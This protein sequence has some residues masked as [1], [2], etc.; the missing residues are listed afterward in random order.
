MSS[1][2]FAKGNAKSVNNEDYEV[3]IIR[4]TSGTD[5]VREFSVGASGVN[6][7]YEN[8]DDTLLVP[9]IVHSRCEVETCWSSGDVALT[10]LIDNLLASQDGD[11][12]LEILR[13]TERIW[14]GT[15]LVEQVDLLE[16]SSTQKLRIVAT[17]GLSL[18]R[19]VDYNDDGTAY[20]GHQIVLDNILNNIQQK[21]LIY[22]Y[23]DE[24]NTT[25]NRI[26]IADD[27]YSTDD[28]V[29]TLLSHPGGT[30]HEN[31]RRMRMH[32]S[33]FQRF[34]DTNQT[35]FASCYELLE[36]FCLTLQLRMYY[37]GNAWTFVPVS[38]SSEEVN[39]YALTY[40]DTYVTSQIV[41]TY[42]YQVDTTN[43]IRQKGAEWVLSLIHI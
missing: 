19:N 13:D 2:L 43:N 8:T 24:Q 32:P 29:M 6:I 27:V 41:S 25:A 12:L 38:L 3:R 10:Q 17:D 37:Y 18:L 9:G 26:E 5:S 14:V 39:G 7:I 31:T 20:T 4:T 28:M 22:N 30:D 40:A 35:I 16:S 42:E 15:I 34:D 33:A 1:F 23:L 36:S 21:W 11:Y